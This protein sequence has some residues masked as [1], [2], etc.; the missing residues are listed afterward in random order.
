MTERASVRHI[1]DWLVAGAPP[2]KLPNEVLQQLCDRMIEAGFNIDRGAAFVMT[3]HPHILGRSFVW[4]R[5]EQV[6]IGQAD[7]SMTGTEE[8]RNSPV[9]EVMSSNRPIRAHLD[10]PQA[11]EYPV[12]KELR[13]A[14]MTDYLCQPI[15]FINGER[16]V[17]SWATKR[18]GGFTENDLAAF[19]AV[20]NPLARIAEVYALRRTAV[21]LLNT[22]VGHEAGTRILSGHIRRGDTESINA[23]IWLA[24]LRG[25]T[26]FADTRPGTEVVALL[27]DFFECLVTA[28]HNHDGEVL[29]FMGDGLL[30]I[31]RI[32]AEHDETE[33]SHK[34]MAAAREA[35][36]RVIELN[37]RR[38]AKGEPP[39]HWG[40]ALHC[41]EVLYGNIG[42]AAR[43]DFTTIGPAVNMAARLEA[44]SKR[45]GRTVMVSSAVAR[46]C[47]PTV[48]PLG[49]HELRGFRET[50]EVFGLIDEAKADAP[51]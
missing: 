27:N 14:G 25:F 7:I 16:H 22:Y 34:A 8:W 32:T 23:A 41:G 44:L 43:L 1:V 28:V 17:I 13:E 47:R 19:E 18:R 48:V 29:K 46:H 11:K 12:Y 30:A 9:I 38:A 24:D 5:G 26:A 45:M 50:E 49:R 6:V 31:F 37:E 39:L 42:G 15:E 20:R 51:A 10:Q 3:L 21:N 35:R 4:H 33:V 36:V 40:V 2:T